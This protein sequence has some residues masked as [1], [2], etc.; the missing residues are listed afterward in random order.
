MGS[1]RIDLA[2]FHRRRIGR[3]ENRKK[4]RSRAAAEAAEATTAPPPHSGTPT[5]GY[6]ALLKMLRAGVT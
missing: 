3:L 2:F 6:E 1:G 4:N 5:H